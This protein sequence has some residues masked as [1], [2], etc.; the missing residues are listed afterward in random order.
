MPTPGEYGE[1]RRAR[2]GVPGPA[3]VRAADDSSFGGGQECAGVLWA[4][5]EVREADG[6]PGLPRL[7]VVLG[8]HQPSAGGVPAVDHSRRVAQDVEV[9][10]PA[11]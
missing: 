6:A 8:S 10:C 9:G 7:A 11:Q 3:A 1:K 4:D 2:L 5:G